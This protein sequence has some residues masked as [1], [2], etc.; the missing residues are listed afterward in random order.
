[1]NHYFFFHII[2][3]IFG[4]LLLRNESREQLKIYLFEIFGILL[5]YRELLKN[6]WPPCELQIFVATRDLNLRLNK[7]WRMSSFSGLK[8]KNN[9]VSTKILFHFNQ[10]L[11]HE[12]K[13]LWRVV[14]HDW[15]YSLLIRRICHGN[16]LNDIGR[17]VDSTTRDT[18]NASVTQLCKIVIHCFNPVFMSS[19]LSSDRVNI[20]SYVIIFIPE[21]LKTPSITNPSMKY[22]YLKNN[23]EL[24]RG[25]KRER[26][27]LKKIEISKFWDS[28]RI[29]F[30]WNNY[31][32]NI[33]PLVIFI[34]CVSIFIILWFL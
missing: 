10:T 28:S 21:K 16:Y 32:V 4:I 29:Y 11:G 2:F 20:P 3:E 7:S 22:T 9:N 18:A 23:N 25:R 13:T 15:S 12:A 26:K 34:C 6:C 19:H 31:C 30:Y 27:R 24:C 33:I 1:M 14:K 17:T 5:S 8:K